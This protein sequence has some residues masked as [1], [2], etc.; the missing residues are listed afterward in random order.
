MIANGLQNV[1]V[2][3]AENLFLPYPS[4]IVIESCGVGRSDHKLSEDV[5]WAETAS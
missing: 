2:W 4:S 1:L 3:F 5:Q